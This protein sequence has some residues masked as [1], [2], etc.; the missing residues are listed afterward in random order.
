MA[1]RVATL[2]EFYR[3]NDRS[4]RRHAEG[5]SN[6]QS[7]LLPQFEAISLNWTLGHIVQY[8]VMAL[9]TMG[10]SFARDLG[11]GSPYWHDPTCVV[12][13]GD[14]R[15]LEDLLADLGETGRLLEEV[16]S[17]AS[18]E[19]LDG[20]IQTYFGDQSRLDFVGRL[21]WH[22]TYHVGQLGL[23]RSLANPAGALS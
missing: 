21:A 11:E 3:S 16:L 5:L 2:I 15:A 22:E 8:R 1:E 23:L 12:K 20:I 10:E 13:P 4:I 19:V 17:G 18:A 14:G 9:T 6:E 7:Y